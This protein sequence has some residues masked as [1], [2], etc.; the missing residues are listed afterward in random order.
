MPLNRDAEEHLG[1]KDFSRRERCESSRANHNLCTT[2]AE[3]AN[4]PIEKSQGTTPTE[5]LLSTLCENTFLKLWSYANPYKEDGK[6]LCDLI[7]VFDDHVFLFFDRESRRFDNNPEDVHLAWRRWQ[8]KVIDKQIRAARGAARYIN[9][10][11]SVFLDPKNN[12]PFPLQIKS[13]MTLHKVIVAHGAKDACKAFSADNIFGSL[14][15]SYTPNAQSTDAIPW[16]FVVRLDKDD[17]VHVLDS[18]NLEILL[19]ELDTFHDLLSYIEEKERAVRAYELLYYCGE[20]DLIAHYF[21]NYDK[22]RR[23]YRIG[24]TDERIDGL[25]IA[26][27]GWQ[28][29]IAMDVYSHRKDANRI[30]YFW[31]DLIQKTC[32]NALDGTLLGN[33]DLFKGKSALREM[34][35]EPRVHRRALSTNML[36]SIRRVANA[37]RPVGRKLSLMPSFYEGTAYVFL[38]IPYDGVS[39]YENDYRPMR[40]NVLEIA[41]GVARNRWSHLDKIIGIAVDVPAHGIDH[42][43]EDFILL[44]CAEWSNETAASYRKANEHWKLFEKAT[45]I[46]RRTLDFPT[47]AGD[48]IVMNKIGRNDPCICGSGRKYKKCCM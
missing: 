19:G 12:D 37:G 22:K 30:S 4:M 17:I 33:A 38:L 42:S 29:F 9:A 23:M 7:A 39:D 36:E 34:A 21:S 27:G 44:E 6:E 13:R 3:S 28:S 31:D 35:R 32:Q 26:E 41:C 40:Q 45:P 10:G 46:Q 20:E 25:S 47:Q 1:S 5:R 24:P 15:I 43:A 11:R 8:S 18:H 14:G 48:G 2:L 16:P